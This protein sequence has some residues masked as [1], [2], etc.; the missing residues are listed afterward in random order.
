V[1][2]AGAWKYAFIYDI[3]SRHYPDLPEKARFISEGEA[4]SRLLELYFESVG[5]AQER[6]ALKLF[7]WPKELM[8]RTIARLVEQQKL[9]IVEHPDHKGQWFARPGLI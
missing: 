4:R 5:A 9:V 6:D 7:G 3:V 8:A 1:A 2:K